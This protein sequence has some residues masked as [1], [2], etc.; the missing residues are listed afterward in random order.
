MI[1]FQL[2]GVEMHGNFESWG[3]NGSIIVPTGQVTT[4]LGELAAF[5]ESGWGGD[6][7]SFEGWGLSNSSIRWTKYY[8]NFRP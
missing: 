6:N 4:S 5:P 2:V 3:F 8:I 7:F 1:L